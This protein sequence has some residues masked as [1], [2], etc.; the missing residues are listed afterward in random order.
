MNMFK[1][2]FAAALISLTL[3]ASSCKEDKKEDPK[4]N[5]PSE[6]KGDV[7]INISHTFGTAPF[8]YTTTF[9]NPS[10]NSEDLKFSDLEYIV[11][12]FKLKGSDGQWY[13]VPETY[14]YVNQAQNQTLSFKLKDVKVQDYTAI[15]FLIGV[16]SIRNVSGA[17]TGGLD[18]STGMFWTW[19]S[20]YI[21]FKVEG[22]SQKYAPNT[23]FT[24]HVG[25]FR[26]ATSAL[27]WNEAAFGSST[28]KVKD[29]SNIINIS[30]DV[31]EVFKTPA[32]FTLAGGRTI[33]TPG[34]TAQAIATNYADMFTVKS[35]Q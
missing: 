13:D 17:Q 15:K 1:N 2:T 9:N 32:P 25:G 18:P 5:T 33:T 4:P 27:V 34:I 26:G 20:G 22:N 28:L 16:D 29:G 3:F 23:K 7:T 8:D 14:F 11:S 21:F 31:S 6:S 12:N 24:Y 19:N 30:G 10:D 35:I